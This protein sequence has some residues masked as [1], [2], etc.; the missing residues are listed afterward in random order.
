MARPEGLEPPT[1]GS[2]VLLTAC[3]H[4]VILLFEWTGRDQIGPSVH[5][6]RNLSA[7][8]G[9]SG[10]RTPPPD[11]CAASSVFVIRPPHETKGGGK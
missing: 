10:L 9:F 2:E 5:N 11:L 8:A 6:I 3:S 7:T 4:A 1:L